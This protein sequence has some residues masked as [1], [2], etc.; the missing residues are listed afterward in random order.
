MHTDI[1]DKFTTHLKNVL[2]RAL[3]LVV[4]TKEDTIFPLHLFWSLATQQGSIG[5]EILHKAGVTDEMVGGLF[6]NATAK[7]PLTAAGKQSQTKIEQVAPKLSSAAKRAIEKSVLTANLYE[8]KYVGTEHLLSGLLQIE[9]PAIKQLLTD[10]KVE[11]KTLRG[12]VTMVLKSTSKF[13]DLAASLGVSPD[14]ELESSGGATT[15]EKRRGK[16]LNSKTPALD[17]FAVDL[18]TTDTQKTI[19]P[20]IGR[21]AEI[22]R[23][24]Q[25]LCRR[26]KNN[27]ILLGDPGVGKTALV[28]GL[29]KRIVEG[30][31]PEVLQGKRILAIDLS[32]I[33]AGTMYRGEFEGRLKQIIDEVK[34]NPEIILFIDE[35]HTIIGAGSA[36]GSLDAANILKPALARGE[37]RCIGATTL[38]EYKKHIESDAALERRFQSVMIEEPSKEK[39]LKILEG[40]KKNYEIFHGVTITRDALVAAVELADRYLQEKFFPD[41]AIDLID[42]AASAIRVKRRASSREK[43]IHSTEEELARL[44]EEKRQAVIQERFIEAIALKEQERALEESY[45]KLVLRRPKSSGSAGRIS[46]R[47]VAQIV[48]RMTG[49]PAEELASTE[50]ERLENL[51]A[52]LT[53][54][55]IGQ[56]EVVR[57]VADLIRR[58]KTGIAHPNRPLAS[59]LFVGPSGVGKTELAKAI[60]EEVFHDKQGLIRL[61]MSEFSEGFS[62][63]KL[64]GAPAGYVGYRDNAKLTDSIKRKPYSVVLFDELEKGHPEVLNILLQMLDEGHLTDATGKTINC[65]NT[66]VIM[67]SNVGSEYVDHAM[68]FRAGDE[69]TA[70][71]SSLL[72]ALRERFRPE[73][74]NRIDRIC[75]FRPLDSGTLAQIVDLQINELNER[76]ASKQVAVNVT[77]AV[78]DW[79]VRH[80]TDRAHG[81]RALRRAIQDHL[82]GQLATYL[83]QT[84]TVTALKE[85]CFVLNGDL[86]TL[87]PIEKKTRQR[88]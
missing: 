17:F 45:K 75:A 59:F 85:F 81:A 38:A 53:K 79:L 86:P 61:D 39:T 78:R 48:S 6:E 88:K 64:I 37:I 3:C 5:T 8:H 72:T 30:G 14:H 26:T 12:Q 22:E 56:D 82:E 58:A 35:V 10:H 23:V 71:A 24:M 87:E 43:K 54:R 11:L 74:L 80:G 36:S 13:P 21:E 31:V 7:L 32:L 44:R 52:T 69:A 27:P 57:A 1:I 25:I 83:L 18:T 70:E 62:I 33:V 19:D 65:K 51:E 15:R 49:I 60:A 16:R 42:E 41:K 20:V 84:P 47:A 29:A 4:D 28:E 55:V 9:D 2:T 63:S 76:L 77:P 73:F 34:A 68:G 50:R 66:V 40:I 67:T 46:T